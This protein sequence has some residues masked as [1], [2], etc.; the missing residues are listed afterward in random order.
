LGFGI[1]I[2]TY[3]RKKTMKSKLTKILCLVMGA[4]L[5]V[6]GTVA[7]TLAYLQDISGTVTNTMSVGKVKITLDEAKVDVYGKPVSGAGRVTANDYKLIPGQAYTKDPT[8]H[9]TKGS[10]ECY[11]FLGIAIDTKLDG[12]LDATNNDI[13]TQLTG[14]DWFPLQLADKSPATWS[15]GDTT[16]TIYYKKTKVPANASKDQDI[17]T[18][19]KFSVGAKANVSG[20]D[21]ATIKVKA[22]AIQSANIAAANGK[23]VHLVAWEAGFK[24]SAT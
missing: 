21:K 2:S 17:Y 1:K 3:E 11:L 15:E 14:N 10:E 7:V 12:V 22:F 5:L 19:S 4:I 9:V 23:S 6:T 20:A 16:Y 8:I 18:F 13:A 24:Q